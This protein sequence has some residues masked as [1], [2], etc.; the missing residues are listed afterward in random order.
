MLKKPSKSTL[1]P[2]DRPGTTRPKK[3]MSRFQASR[4]K[5]TPEIAAKSENSEQDAQDKDLKFE[6]KGFKDPKKAQKRPKK[7]S[8]PPK[9]PKNA[10]RKPKIVARKFT[11]R[12]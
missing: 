2:K 6:P 9:N 8:K 10:F 11:I 5:K 4:P 1:D 12:K 3:K 7:R